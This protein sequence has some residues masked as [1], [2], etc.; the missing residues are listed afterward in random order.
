MRD[1]VMRD[2]KLR[3]TVMRDTVMLDTAR[4][5]ARSMRHAGVLALAVFLV[6]LPVFGAPIHGADAG[7]APANAQMEPRAELA[8]PLDARDLA[9]EP[10]RLA[11]ALRTGPTVVTFW[12]TWC[13]PCAREFPALQML[14]AVQSG[15]VTLLGINEDGPRNRAKLAAFA[16]S[17]G[18]TARILPDDDG[19]IAESFRVQA[20]PT[21]IVI[22]TRGRIVLVQ[23]GYRAGDEALVART[24]ERLLG[25]AAAAD[26]GAVAK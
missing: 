25:R 26:S 1:A 7:P 23:Q 2:T 18:L 21:T 4:R 12:A 14:S 16:R 19:T 17:H 10:V 5:D 9:G 13:K 6:G 15:Q 22:D 24:L 8:P 3:D 11:D 20:F